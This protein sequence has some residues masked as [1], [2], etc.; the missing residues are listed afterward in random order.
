MGEPGPDKAIA[1][2]LLAVVAPADVDA[3]LTPKLT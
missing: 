3:E 1:P 2:A